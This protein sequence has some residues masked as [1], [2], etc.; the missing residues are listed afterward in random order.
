MTHTF[1]FRNIRQ[2]E[3]QEAS[4]IENICF[5]PEEAC[6]PEHM[7]ERVMHASDLFLTAIDQETGKMAGFING[8]STSEEKL[9]DAFYTDISLYDPDGRNIMILGVDVLP[10]YRHQGLARKMMQVYQKQASDGK[11]KMLVLTCLDGKVEMYRKFGFID[12]GISESE[13]GSETW[14]EMVYK[15]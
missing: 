11:Y 3:I 12:N 4:E 7:K 6:S 9:R 13:W 8:I 10:Q 15:L 1:T 2:D 14:H 5:P